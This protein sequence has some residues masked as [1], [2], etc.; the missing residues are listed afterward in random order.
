[1]LREHAA[2]IFAAESSRPCSRA[3]AATCASI[4][5]SRR[6]RTERFFGFGAGASHKVTAAVRRGGRKRNAAPCQEAAPVNESAT[7]MARS[8][9]AIAIGG[10]GG[11]AR[12]QNRRERAT[13]ALRLRMPRW[14]TRSRNLSRDLAD[15][16]S[17]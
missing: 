4:S 5:S 14:A 8:A 1:M 2:I 15:E 3:A 13:K 6:Y 11:S 12:P 16:L 9:L 7:R 10:G 17:S